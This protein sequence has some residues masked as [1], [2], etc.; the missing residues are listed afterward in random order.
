MNADIIQLKSVSKKYPQ[1][2]NSWKRVRELLFNEKTSEIGSE[3]IWALKDISFSV[4]KGEAFGIIGENGAGKSTLLSI[5]AGI[6]KPTYGDSIVKGKISSLLELGVGFHPEFTGLEN[7]HLYGTILGLSKS[8]I[9]AK[10]KSIIAFSEL[11]D[12]IHKPLKTYSTGMTVRL[13]FSVAMTIE[14]DILIVDEAL[15]VGDIHFQK[16]SLDAIIKFKQ[17]GGTILF[18]SHS[19]YH[20]LHLCDRALWLKN[21]EPAI[22]DKAFAVVEAYENYMRGKD[23]LN[24]DIDIPVPISDAPVWIT[25]AKITKDGYNVSTIHTGDNINLEINLKSKKPAQIHIA[26]GLDRN[27]NVNVYATSTEME[28]L[29][30]LMVERNATVIFSI[31][32]HRLLSG[33]YNFVILIMDEKAFNVLYKYRTDNFSVARDTKELGI[34]KI[35]HEWRTNRI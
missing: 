26:I 20:V 29:E 27:D 8:D 2:K 31:T 28:G 9:G 21:G 15:S 6:V 33:E 10:V 24:P 17:N 34:Y 14:P 5:I 23:S 1:T 3:R 7:I 22:L 32:N 19:M 16:K 18:A 30:P 13:A 35:N 4:Q 12:A 25:N 11:G